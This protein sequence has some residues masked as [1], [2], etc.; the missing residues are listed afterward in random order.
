[1]GGRQPPMHGVHTGFGTESGDPDENHGKKELLVS[2]YFCHIEGT[3]LSECTRVRREICHEEH[4]K[5]TQQ[6]SS[7]RI[8]QILECR[9][10][11]GLGHLV[12]DQRHGG[13][14]RHLKTQVQCDQISG[15]THRQHGPEADKIKC[16]KHILP[17]LHLHILKRVEARDCVEQHDENHKVPAYSVR[18]KVRAD[19]VREREQT[20]TASVQNRDRSQNIRNE[21]SCDIKNM[22]L[23]VFHL[24]DGDDDSRN[25]RK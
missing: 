21:Q 20:G 19:L 6:G 8:K 16:E 2:R 11:R 12:Q 1:M 18:C 7:D 22:S 24:R 3:S 5:K 9:G 25:D 13:E 15:K 23:P 4:G 17:L 10:Y 14:R